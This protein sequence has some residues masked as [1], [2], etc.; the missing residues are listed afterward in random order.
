MMEWP[1]NHANETCCMSFK[2]PLVEQSVRRRLANTARPDGVLLLAALFERTRSRPDVDA[3][4]FRIDFKDHRE[5]INRLTKHQFI[6]VTRR[7]EERYRLCLVALPLIDSNAARSMLIVVDRVLHY[8]S[9]QYQSQPD[10]KVTLSQLCDHLDITEQS[11]SEAFGYLVNTPI[12]A[13][14][15][16]EYPDS[17]DWWIVPT[18]KSLDFPNLASLLKLL[19]EWTTREEPALRPIQVV[20]GMPHLQSPDTAPPTR[21]DFLVRRAKDHKVIALFLVSVFAISLLATGLDA[22]ISL[23]D[24][25]SSVF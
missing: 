2:T 4:Q 3:R 6:S 12:A 1:G 16:S 25:I 14:R 7:S 19:T 10:G 11:A 8:L 21:F 9:E 18:E 15:K 5:A 24:R 20:P 13:P 23:Y 17:A 22:L